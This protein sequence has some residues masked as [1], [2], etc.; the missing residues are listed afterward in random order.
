MSNV[1][2]YFIVFMHL[3]YLLLCLSYAEG[4]NSYFR[5]SDPLWAPQFL[6]L[7]LRI[8]FLQVLVIYELLLLINLSL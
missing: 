6:V 4:K 7:V 8:H 3:C 5:L 2:Y 1:I